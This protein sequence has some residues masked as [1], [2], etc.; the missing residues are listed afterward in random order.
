[1]SL[2]Q[3]Y[4]AGDKNYLLKTVQAFNK[5]ILLNLWTSAAFSGYQQSENPMGLEDDFTILLREKISE[6]KIILDE[7]YDLLA[8]IYRF[9]YGDNQL[10]F[11]WDGRT[12]MQFYD[13]L[14][15]ETFSEWCRELCLKPEVYRA[16]VKASLADEK[17]N[18]EFLK[19]SL[20]RA[21]LQKFKVRITRSQ[22]LIAKAA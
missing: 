8:A 11:M 6:G 15:K 14:W 13:E 21:I 17:T 4:F 22:S 18:S 3:K 20:K 10:A 16:I 12:H 9:K 19:S 1:M 5:E 7:P 2:D